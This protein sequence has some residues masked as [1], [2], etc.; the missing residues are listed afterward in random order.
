MERKSILTRS[1][2][3]S[4]NKDP[5]TVTDVMD[6]AL[7]AD[8]PQWGKSV[9]NLLNGAINLLDEKVNKLINNL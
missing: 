5:R 1:Q 7:P 6:T 4:T 2:A 8:T 3:N 9:F